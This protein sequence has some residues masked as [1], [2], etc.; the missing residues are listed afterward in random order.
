MKLG[1]EHT[2]ATKEKLRVACAAR[3]A[4][5]RYDAEAIKKNQK[6][7]ADAVRGKPRT[8]DA[9]AKI[10]AAHAH[11]DHSWR[12]TPEGR[13][14]HRLRSLEALKIKPAI[15]RP[16]TAETKLKM[17]S[18]ASKR[19][20]RD[21]QKKSGTAL[22]STVATWLLGVDFL[23]QSLVEGDPFHVWD[24][25]IPSLRLLIEADG[26]YWHGCQRCGFKGFPYNRR[27]DAAKNTVAVKLGW[28]LIRV[29]ECQLVL[30][31]VEVEDGIR[32]R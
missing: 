22:E 19:V 25:V 13:E 11:V 24:F 26:C 4:S 2:E 17:S 31:R 18:S 27:S 7:A 29:Q 6:R 12:R 3:W 30:G 16:H 32:L 21:S 5:G 15:G 23:S 28:R 14:A 9:K 1:R 8:E 10:R 20:A